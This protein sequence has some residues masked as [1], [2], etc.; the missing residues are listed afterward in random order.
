MQL[1]AVNNNIKD[2]KEKAKANA[3]ANIN[4]IEVSFMIF[5]TG[6]VLIVGMCEE[7]ILNHIYDFLTKLLKTE[8]ENICQSIITAEQLSLKDK[9][10]K[11]R[12]KTVMITNTTNEIMNTSSNQ[13]STQEEIILKLKEQSEQVDTV[14]VKVKRS[15]KKKN[16]SENSI[17]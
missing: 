9:K 5:R 7:N 14:Q 12:R 13:V 4:V 15:Y 6:S 8:F 11:V 17:L 2:K 3:Q 1:S 16:K 10:K